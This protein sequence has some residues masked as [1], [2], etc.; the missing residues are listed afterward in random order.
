MQPSGEASPVTRDQ[1]NI[2][3]P[4]FTLVEILI[5]VA[6]L[7]LLAGSLLGVLR[8]LDDSKHKIQ[9]N[10]ALQTKVDQGAAYLRNKLSAADAIQISDADGVQNACLTLV[11]RRIDEFKGFNFAN[12]MMI[13]D[14]DFYGFVGNPMQS[15]SF[16]MRT[17]ATT[18]SKQ[19]LVKWGRHDLNDR[20]FGINLENGR[21][22][23]DFGGKQAQVTSGPNLRDGEWHHVLVTYAGGVN[24]AD[25]RVFINGAIESVSFTGGGTINIGTDSSTND[26]LRLGAQTV[27]GDMQYDGVIGDLRIW[28]T[29]LDL[30]DAQ[31][32]FADRQAADELALPSLQLHWRMRAIP[33]D[34]DTVPDSSVHGRS[35]DLYNP[36]VA[37]LLYETTLE[38]NTRQQ[39]AMY[40]IDGDGLY[41]L[42]Y[43]NFAADCPDNPV[44]WDAASIDIYA[45]SDAGFFD[46]PSS[47]P[48]LVN[49]TF[50]T[51][52]NIEGVEAASTSE[53]TRK[54]ATT[55]S[56]KKAEL[57][58]ADSNLQFPV[59]LTNPT[60]C[61][62]DRA[63][64]LI[65]TGYDT[66][67]DE[68]FLQNA[69]FVVG[70]DNVTYSNI[71]FVPD[72]IIGVW[73]SGTGVL[74]LT[75]NT[76]T[77]H[78]PEVWATALQATA[79][80]PIG[81]S[82]STRKN[83]LFSLGYLPFKTANGYHYYE[84][85][86]IPVGSQISY[87]EAYRRSRASETEFC[88]MQGYLATITSNDENLFLTDRFLTPDGGL[89]RGWIG[90]TDNI[91][92][93]VW[94]WAD[95]PEA[96]EQFWQGLGNGNPVD[97]NG[98]LITSFTSETY[99]Y[100]ISANDLRLHVTTPTD[101]TI[102][103]MFHRWGVNRGSPIKNQPDDSGGEDY[104][105]ICGLEAGHGTWNDLPHDFPCRTEGNDVDV[106]RVCGYY[107]EWG[108][109]DNETDPG[110]VLSREFDIADQREFCQ[111]EE[112]LAPAVTMT[113]SGA[114]L[115]VNGVL[116]SAND[117]GISATYRI[118]TTEPTSRVWLGTTT[119]VTV[120]N[121]NTAA[122]TVTGTVAYL[123]NAIASLNYASDGG[124]S[125]ADTIRLE[126][127]MGT[128][129][130][131]KSISVTVN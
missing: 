112:L 28:D 125:G 73:R 10:A 48:A 12:K 38:D 91:T 118:S 76:D 16:W 121:A 17:P 109:R 59:E 45:P 110:L 39:L 98:N 1:K 130:F 52:G 115:P 26:G 62:I 42:H 126:V 32:I 105:Q 33:A 47:D 104:M 21:I 6:I 83:I 122:M 128:F 89:P 13:T 131:D 43:S 60:N 57:C 53:A 120:A 2:R 51:R 116:L 108:G 5:A 74:E 107:V 54:I 44:G 129:T 41:T 80:R 88:G 63:F 127:E 65:E 27:A 61:D 106:Y 67:Q 25:T 103:Q 34:E 90:G 8:Y 69:A 22:N 117:T 56:F 95:G 87:H 66:S 29:A 55:K 78:A 119:N 100:D 9:N 75:S 93:G 101:E 40:D 50:G 85:Y 79:Y 84:F 19:Y 94:R 102:T 4:G 15:V 111:I 14:V 36:S 81:T 124:F 77:S 64:A 20:H 23:V 31:Q 35:G 114:V 37:D 58:R 46:A 24:P 72:D 18:A 70:S 92:E 113:T 99:D 71:P 123:R 86:S 7:G 49:F 96:G 82:Y 68:L 3:N 97:S 11:T 30:I